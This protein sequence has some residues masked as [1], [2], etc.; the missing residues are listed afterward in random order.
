M[1]IALPVL[2][3]HPRWLLPTLRA[4]RIAWAKPT[5]SLHHTVALNCLERGW[6]KLIP[7]RDGSGPYLFRFWPTAPRM[8]ADGE[9]DSGGGPRLHWM[10]RGDDDEA[11]HDHPWDLWGRILQGGY[12]EHVPPADWLNARGEDRRRG[13]AWNECIVVRKTGDTFNH[14]AEDLHCVGE[15]LDPAIRPNGTIDPMRGSWS[16]VQMGKRRRDWYFHPPGQPRVPWRD[17]L[18]VRRA[19]KAG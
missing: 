13:P 7:T 19:R 9:A 4:C 5:A 14:R 3:S 10:V 11:L 8:R 15:L 16:E 1:P 18:D 17:Y 6:W 12:H 2:A